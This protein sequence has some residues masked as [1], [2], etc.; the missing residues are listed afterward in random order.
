M[1]MIL[2]LKAFCLME[3]E[4]YNKAIESYEIIFDDYNYDF[5][6]MVLNNLLLLTTKS[7]NQNC[8]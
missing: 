1:D 5:D 7:I 2:Q 6:K 4:D 8:Y 3:L